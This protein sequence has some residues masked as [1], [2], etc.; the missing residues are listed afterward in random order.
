L[1]ETKRKGERGPEECE[2]ND[3]QEEEKMIEGR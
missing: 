1:E 3:E 2:E